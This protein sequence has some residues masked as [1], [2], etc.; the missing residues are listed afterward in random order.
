M[1]CELPPPLGAVL[2]ELRRGSPKRL[3]REGGCVQASHFP[4]ALQAPQSR[5]LSKITLKA[6][7][8]FTR[9][10]GRPSTQQVVKRQNIGQ[11][12]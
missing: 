2:P 8:L 6:D 5:I 3:R 9:V 10:F 1:F 12:A 4:Q 7:L 11:T